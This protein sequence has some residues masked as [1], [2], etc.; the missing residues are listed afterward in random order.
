MAI[1]SG[2]TAFVLICIALVTLMVP[3]LGLFYGGLVRKK[4]IISMVFLSF[5]AL[6]IASIQWVLVGYSLAFGPDIAGLIGGLDYVG[7]IGIGL[8]D[9][10]VEGIPDL[11][12]IAFQMIFAGLS[13][14]I[15]TSG[16]AERVKLGAFILFGLLWTTLVYDPLAHW[17]WGGG[18]AHALGALDFAGGTVVHISA[19][20]GALAAAFVI[21]KRSGFGEAR[22]VS[23]PQNIP[24]TLL[25]AGLLWVGWFGFNG[26][27]ALA[28][29]GIAAL[30]VM[31]TA[32]AAAAGALVWMAVSSV[33]GKPSAVGLVSGALAGLVGITPAAGYV[34]VFP[35]ILI[36]GVAS[37]VCY[38]A[39]LFRVK[40]GWDE[41]LDAW[42]IHGVGGL[43]GAVA[44]G[45][46]A[47]SALA[48]VGGLIEGNVMQFAVNA[49]D[50]VIAVVFSFA[51][52]YVIALFVK[53]VTGLRV[54]EIEEELGLDI[55]NHGERA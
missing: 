51:V 37:V 9:T 39:L 33:K 27:S 7:L 25:G 21:G 49:G 10:L 42:A 44:T 52:T 28:A 38:Y 24:L 12:F 34:E 6:S 16:F 23:A 30:A 13:L 31:N 55:S 43:W 53:K 26:G 50:A 11:L 4:N 1:D 41:S 36:G 40:K 3:A 8:D 48:G 54:S 32:L 2:S 20:F 22:M 45:I 19:G 15:I 5:L 47:S 14:A 46:F 17:A 35:A 18:W 29:D